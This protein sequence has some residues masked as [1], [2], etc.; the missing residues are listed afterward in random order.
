MPALLKVPMTS[1]SVRQK[2][3]AAQ[4]RRIISDVLARELAD[5]RVTGLITVTRVDI[6]PDLRE[7]RVHISVM[8]QKGT[9]GTVIHGLTAATRR[10][11]DSVKAGLPTRTSPHLEFVLDETLKKEADMFRLI[12]KVAREDQANKPEASETP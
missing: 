4:V 12:D 1:A 9:P 11:Q 8:G 10:I 6:T 5:P 7:A 2:K 3:V